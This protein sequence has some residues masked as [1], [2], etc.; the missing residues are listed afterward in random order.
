[1]VVTVRT[2]SQ[3]YSAT[4]PKRKPICP[5]ARGRRDQEKGMVEILVELEYFYLRTL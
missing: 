4:D 2:A 1:M 5:Q 3:D